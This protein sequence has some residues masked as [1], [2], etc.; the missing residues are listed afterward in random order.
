MKHT[1]KT[2]AVCP[3]C[4]TET[5]AILATELRRGAGTVYQ[6][7][8]CH[9]GFLVD[10]KKDLAAYYARDYRQQA[11]HK[12]DGAATDP[13]EIFESYSRYQGARLALLSEVTASRGSIL[14]IGASAGQFLRHLDGTW[15]RRCAIEF[16]LGC[17]EYMKRM[18]IEVSDK[19][20]RDLHFFGEK[21]DAVCA[22]QVMEHVEDPLKFLVDI[23]TVL[24]PGGTALIEVPNLHD[25]L[26]GLWGIEEYDHFYFHE[27][28]RFY[29]SGRALKQLA[30]T[31]GFRKIE[32]RF[33]QDFNILNHLHWLLNRTPQPDCHVGLAPP[34]LPGNDTSIREWLIDRIRL[35]NH[36]YIQ[37]LTSTG[38][39]SNITMILLG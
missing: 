23:K 12:A 18:D 15:A 17:C 5:D 22:F 8:P 33:T 21:F 32:I 19:H 27:D 31:A 38:T 30:K 10:E 6:C 2:P 14:E 34:S 28:H 13:E 35:L 39:T 9:L 37:K 26:R 7:H 4:G 24:A 36:E 20:L 1:T 29:F 16:D 3:I 25:S 11:S